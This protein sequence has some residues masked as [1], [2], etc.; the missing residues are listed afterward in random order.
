MPRDAYDMVPFDHA[1]KSWVLPTE[2]GRRYRPVNRVFGA[3]SPLQHPLADPPPPAPVF[4]VW[5][6]VR[7]PT[8]SHYGTSAKAQ[9]KRFMSESSQ[10]PNSALSRRPRPRT[11]KLG[12]RNVIGTSKAKHFKLQGLKLP[13][14]AKILARGASLGET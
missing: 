2:G 7:V 5:R 1:T 8:E 10:Q 11:R 13:D 6:E 14:P 4:T 12:V 3:P 9:I